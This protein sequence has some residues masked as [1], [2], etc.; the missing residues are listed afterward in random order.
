LIDAP[1]GYSGSELMWSPDS[2]SV[3]VTGVHLP[4]GRFG[5]EESRSEAS[6]TFVAEVKIAGGEIIEVTDRNLK[7]VGWDPQTGL[8]KFETRQNTTRSANRRPRSIFRK[9]QE[10]GQASAMFLSSQRHG[11]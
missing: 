3:I 10:H 1:I 11:T 5:T 8:W 6:G 4:L 2:Q 7:L 9:R